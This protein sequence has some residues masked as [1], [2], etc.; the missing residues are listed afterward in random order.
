MCVLCT[1]QIPVEVQLLS[2]VVLIDQGSAALEVIDT[3]LNRI[4][5]P[6]H[7]LFAYAH[8]IPQTPTK[9]QTIV[10]IAVALGSGICEIK[11]L[12]GRD[13]RRFVEGS[14]INIGPATSTYQQHTRDSLTQ[15]KSAR[16]MSVRRTKVTYNLARVRC[17][18][19]L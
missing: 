8:T 19:T 9:K 1:I 17:G 6:G 14:R 15:K 10:D 12:D 4:D 13:C 3:V 11:G 16:H 18:S 2:W 5:T 7:R